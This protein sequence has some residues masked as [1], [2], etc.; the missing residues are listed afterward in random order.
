MIP[1]ISGYRFRTKDL[2]VH[3]RKP[4][5]SAF[6]R[7]RNGADFLAQTVCTHI[8]HYDEI[9][10]VFN[11]CTDDT[12]I[13]V[14]QL[15]DRYPEKVRAFHYIDRV[16]PLGHPTYAD[17]A[18]DAPNTMANYSNFALAQTRYTVATKLDDDHVCLPSN[19]VPLLE[20]IRLRDFRLGLEM[21]C[22]SGL[23]LY[24]DGHG[25]GVLAHDP[26]SGS[27]DIGYFE[28]SEKTYFRNSVKHEVF[29]KKHLRR[30]YVG[31]TYLHC[32]YL[33]TGQGF[34]NYEVVD[35]PESRFARK[36]QRFNKNHR[37]EPLIDFVTPY[38]HWPRWAGMSRYLP[39]K[40]ALQW[41]RACSIYSDAHTLNLTGI[42]SH[43]AQLACI[44]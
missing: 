35:H 8:A 26:Y 38:R 23:N 18:D 37:V 33:K 11:Q 34:D 17:L 43:S 42:M 9:I 12:E 6:M 5:I 44:L 20:T 24:D 21:M 28:V 41:S 3:T 27:G 30:H 13:I 25:L 22:F 1:T 16:L 10:I 19:L 40:W 39:Q 29:Q 32:K 36:L 14:Q 4:G 7:V 2:N 15:V 31:L